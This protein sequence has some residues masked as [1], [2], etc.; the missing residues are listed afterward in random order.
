MHDIQKIN[1]VFEQGEQRTDQ[2]RYLRREI[3]AKLRD[4]SKLVG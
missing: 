3:I 2:K 4:I 1:D